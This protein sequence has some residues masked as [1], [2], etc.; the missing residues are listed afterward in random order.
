MKLVPNWKKLHKS[1]TVVLSVV[2]T[3]VSLF[4]IILPAMG[5]LQPVLD[6]ATY[7]MIMFLLTIGIGVGRYIKQES[8]KHVEEDN[9][10]KQS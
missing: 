4:E 2:A 5:L 7:G 3:L 8:V 9:D 10:D 1:C 6:P